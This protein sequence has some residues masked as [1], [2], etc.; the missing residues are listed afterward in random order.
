MLPDLFQATVAAPLTKM[1]VNRPMADLL[2]F[3]V[4]L[5][6]VNGQTLPSGPFSS[7]L[8]ARRGSLDRPISPFFRPKP[9][10]TW[11]TE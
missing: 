4:I 2:V 1:M 7:R 11:K 8:Q 3:G 10:E 5:I 6:F 9:P